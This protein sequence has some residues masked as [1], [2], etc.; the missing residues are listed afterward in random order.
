MG[1]AAGAFHAPGLKAISRADV[2]VL[3]IDGVDGLTAQ[4]AHVAGMRSGQAL[5]IA[6]NKWDAVEDKKGTTFDQYVEW[7]QH[8]APFLDFAP[9]VS[10]SA[11]TGQRVHR[12]LELA[13]DVWAERRKRVPTGELNRLLATASD[14]HQA[15]IV[16]GKR[17]KLFY[18]TQAS[19]APPTF[20]FFAREAG[21]VHF[22]Y[23]RYLENRPVRASFLDA[24]PLVFR[25]RAGSIERKATKRSTWSAAAVTAG[26]DP[27]RG[28]R[29]TAPRDERP[30]PSWI[31]DG[32]APGSRSSSGAWGTTLRSSW[33][34][35]NPSRCSA[36]RRDGDA[37]PGGSPERA[38][39]SVS[40]C[41]ARPPD[42]GLAELSARAVI[43]AV[44]SSHL[45]ETMT[46][47]G[48]PSHLGR[49]PVRGQG[50]E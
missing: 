22:S 24:H 48:L 31:D 3:L 11:K 35:R 17:P 29:R 28:D 38:P 21:S 27:G 47:S 19:V 26:H 42:G 16:E 44:P 7:I 36:T 25:E 2:A 23:Q 32:G 37:A 4:D 8:E 12:V 33:R 41:R 14:R 45:R 30:G 10:I 15:P 20:V 13:V 49:R 39:T 9:V 18:A 46:R 34:A 1:P 5:V 6:I 43:V 50:L 40:S